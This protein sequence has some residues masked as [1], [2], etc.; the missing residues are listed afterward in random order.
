MS[1]SAVTP[2]PTSSFTRH[3]SRGGVIGR[4]E[5]TATS[6]F[7]LLHLPHRDDRGVGIGREGGLDAVVAGERLRERGQARRRHD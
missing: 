5:S 4:G 3:M 6:C 1:F 2:G 7:A